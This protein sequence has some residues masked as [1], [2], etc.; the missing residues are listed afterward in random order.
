MISS[1]S[2]TGRKNNDWGGSHNDRDR[3]FSS[4][5]SIHHSAFNAFVPRFPAG[6]RLRLPP[7]PA[8][9]SVLRSLASVALSPVR[10]TISVFQIPTFMLV[11]CG[12][13]V[14]WRAGVPV[15]EFTAILGDKV[16]T[17]PPN[18]VA[19]GGPGRLVKL[20]LVSKR[21]SGWG[22]PDSQTIHTGRAARDETG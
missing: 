11:L 14:K 15:S 5:L 9:G 3:R 8:S 2:A 19:T 6:R 20:Q 17:A 21:K 4:T 18:V 10:L 12:F 7:I 13:S 1:P 16:W 22:V